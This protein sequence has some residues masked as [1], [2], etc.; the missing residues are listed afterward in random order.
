MSC[1]FCNQ[2]SGLGHYCLSAHYVETGSESLTC[3]DYEYDGKV[4]VCE[5]TQ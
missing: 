1:M 5:D 2:Y 3:D 4:K